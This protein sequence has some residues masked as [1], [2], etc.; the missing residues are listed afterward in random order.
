[1]MEFITMRRIEHLQK[2]DRIANLKKLHNWRLQ[3]GH[4]WLWSWRREPGHTEHGL[5]IA[6]SVPS[7]AAMT[8]TGLFVSPWWTLAAHPRLLPHLW[9]APKGSK[10]CHWWWNAL[11]LVSDMVPCMH[12]TRQN[13]SPVIVPSL[14]RNV[15]M[16]HGKSYFSWRNQLDSHV[17]NKIFKSNLLISIFFLSCQC[18]ASNRN[19]RFNDTQSL[20]LVPKKNSSVAMNRNVT[21]LYQNCSF[22]DLC[23]SKGFITSVIKQMASFVLAKIPSVPG[24]PKTCAKS[25]SRLQL[26]GGLPSSEDL[27]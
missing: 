3:S 12:T 11:L 18:R 27:F 4:R 9:S 20:G 10:G 14:V 21:N 16:L 8:P 24:I 15:L 2:F 23:I 13:L 22:L 26:T 19:V 25:P 5:G 6:S 17:M 7:F 1:M